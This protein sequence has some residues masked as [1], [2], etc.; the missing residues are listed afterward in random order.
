MFKS[1]KIYSGLNIDLPLL[2]AELVDF[3]YKRQSSVQAEGDFS[4]RGGIVDIFPVSFELPIRI[5]LSD[6]LI[7]SIKAFGPSTG[8]LLWEHKIV[9][10]LPARKLRALK[11]TP[12]TEDFP[13]SS[14]I[15]LNVGDYV[16]HNQHGI[17]RFLGLEKIRHQ[18]KVKDHLVIEY[19]RQEKLYVP[20][21]SMHLVQKYIAFHAKKPKLYRLGGKEW[22]RVKE[23][24]RKG[25]QK[26]A[27]D[28]LSLQAMRLAS[29][30]FTYSKDSDWQKEFEDGFPY[31]ETPDQVKVAQEVKEDMQSGRLMDRLLCGDVG[32]GK[33]EVAMRAAFKAVMDN[34]QVAYLVPTTILAEQHYQNFS[35]RLKKYPVNIEL[36][37]RFKT[38]REQKKAVNGLKDGSVDIVI[39]THRLLSEDV[40]FKDL[41]LVIIDEE[42][43]FGVKNKEKLK[44][45]R[46]STN[47]LTLTATPI[48]RTLYISLMGGRDLSVIN[49]PPENRLPI[50]TIVVEYDE[51]LVRQ[52]IVREVSRHGQ[53]FFLHNRIE[54]IERIKD[55]L[56]RMLPQ[57]VSF[58]VGHGQ[59]H[60][61][62][63]EAVM[64]SFI[65]GE[66]DCLVSTMIIESGIDIPNANTIIVNNAHMF[67]LSDLHQLR[68]RVGR[69][70]R[71]AY[72]Y[73]MIPKNLILDKD[74]K[75]RLHAIS[76]YSQLGSGFNI[77][78]ED[79]EIRGAGNL[80]G[81]EQHGFISSV[82]FDLYCRLLR[83]AI[84]SLKKAG[85]FNEGNN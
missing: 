40:S 30:G 3:G 2:L 63:L 60:P 80:L 13:L 26:M 19:D 64:A 45:M 29:K 51:D 49:T 15:D 20:V 58:A 33:T 81:V 55:K 44:K 6:N 27:W 16:V 57:G 38:G 37:C 70:N 46:L 78:M 83:E 21:E 24:A 52:A 84:S 65:R 1:L 72:A 69:F 85:V 47:V 11:S 48:P 12:I 66:I 4:V 25:I 22:S 31:D 42:Q 14:F 8:E 73:F 7:T 18:E 50:H 62:E 67:G 54:D 39:G 77:A 43:R 79:L 36:L 71:S 5:D 9:I 76:E 59:M 35:Q 23:R 61:K 74:V 53:V 28:L 82:G 68:G 56:L 75:K 10:I 41:G 17:G 34:K 32:Y